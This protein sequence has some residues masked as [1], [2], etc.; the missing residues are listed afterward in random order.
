MGYAPGVA[1]RDDLAAAKAEIERLRQD[2][3]D[4]HARIAALEAPARSVEPSPSVDLVPAPERRL[5][6]GSVYYDP[7]QT[8]FPLLILLRAGARAGLRRMPRMAPVASNNLLVIL[9]AALLR[10]L[11]LFVWRPLYLA[12]LVL[13]ALPW[14]ALVA[15]T[16]SVPLLPIVALAR[17][18]V[19][20]E[21][22]R[23]AGSG[24]PQGKASDDAGAMAIWVLICGTMP[25]LLVFLIPL[26]VGHGEGVSE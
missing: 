15:V 17:L 25:P 8:Y 24:W 14:A 6:L 23:E 12:T 21:I 3:A 19:G 18:R 2:L 9:G 4:A 22:P 7:P 16:V 11:V 10:L 5:A 13:V 20:G 1:Y 26:L